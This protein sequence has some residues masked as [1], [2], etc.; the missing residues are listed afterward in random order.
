MYK[1]Q[2]YIVGLNLTLVRKGGTEHTMKIELALAGKLLAINELPLREKDFIECQ[3][4]LFGKRSAFLYMVVAVCCVATF[5]VS[6][7][8]GQMGMDYR[9]H[10]GTIFV[11][12]LC[13]LVASVF[14]FA[15]PI[16]LGKLRY[17]QYETSNSKRKS[18]AFYTDHFEIMIDGVTIGIYAYLSVRRI[19][20]S[21]NLFIMVLPNMV[22]LAVRCVGIPDE[23]WSEIEYQITVAMNARR[24]S[25]QTTGEKQ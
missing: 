3:R 1:E 18:V 4:A 5:G 13:L 2:L 23:R 7:I 14:Y 24:R 25:D 8:A 22:Y 10:I 15:V 20:K 19:I 6:G 21:E 17:R 12:L 9:V 16:W 11:V